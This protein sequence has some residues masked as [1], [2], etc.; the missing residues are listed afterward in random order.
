MTGE[1]FTVFWN[2]TYPETTLLSHYLK[3]KYADRWFRIH[4]LPQSKR[5]ANTAQE[6][7]IL[8]MRQNKIMT[9]LLGK[10]ATFLMITGD[11]FSAGHH[12]LHPLS[13]IS[14]LEN[15]HFTPLEHI[16]LHKLSPDEYDGGIYYRPR[17]S[18]Q[19]WR[20]GKFDAALK[21]IANDELRVLFV[22]VENNCIIA[23][24]DGGIDI[25]LKDPET[26]NS[27][28][29]NYKDWLSAREDGR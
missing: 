12:E 7:E 17:F 8:L 15:I 6:W 22:S 11:Y 18:P 26:K 27:Y 1:E 19:T 5:Y 14:S 13:A 29:E 20:N 2:S 25:I 9:D 10:D 24:Y 21:D 16:D 28:K 23:P 3:N 4:S